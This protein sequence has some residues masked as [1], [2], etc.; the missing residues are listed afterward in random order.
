MLR[1]AKKGGT[2]GGSEVDQARADEQARQDTIRNGT[3][4]ISSMFDSQFTPD[5]FNKQAQN[6]TDYATPQLEDQTKEATKQLTFALDRRGALDSS[7]RSSLA[8]QLEQ[9][10]AL[11]AADIAGK[12]QDYKTS[13][14][15]NVEGARSN[16]IGTLNATGDVDSAVN[17][18]TARAQVLSQVPGYSPLTA[19]FADF[20]NGLGTQAAAERAYSYGA[21]AKPTYSTGLFGTPTGAVVN[22]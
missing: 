8:A 19:L 3:S 11:A 5:F 13:A 4:R 12:A 1:V 22:R 18:A 10:R 17:G 15:T 21:G 16:L 7:S 6:Y 20:T 2:D 9:K 14:Q